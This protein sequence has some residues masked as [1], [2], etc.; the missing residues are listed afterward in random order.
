MP[1]PA[2]RGPQGRSVQTEGFLSSSY[3]AF[4]ISDRVRI[5]LS[6]SSRRSTNYFDL[7]SCSRRTLWHASHLEHEDLILH[8]AYRRDRAVSPTIVNPSA[9]DAGF[10][11][12]GAA[13]SWARTS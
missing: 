11:P 8:C 3:T 12:Q 6:F 4:P 2:W 10:S 9:S 13:D 7:T 5:E 1:V